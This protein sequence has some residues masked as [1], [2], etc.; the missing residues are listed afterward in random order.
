MQFFTMMRQRQSTYG[1]SDWPY[2]E[3]VN[4]MHEPEIRNPSYERTSSDFA[5]IV[6]YTDN[7]D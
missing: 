4:T 7:E 6:S 1:S 2:T 3:P 5:P